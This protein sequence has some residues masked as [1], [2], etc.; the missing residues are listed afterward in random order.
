MERYQVILT[1]DGTRYIGY[2]IQARH[3]ADLT[4][5][6]V[7]ENALRRLGWQGTHILAAGR[8][9]TGVH[10]TGQVIAFDLEWKQTPQKLLSALNAHLPNDI[11]ALDVRVVEPDFHPRYQAISRCYRYRLFS[12]PIRQPLLERYAWRIWP[13]VDISAMKIVAGQLC[14]VQD[15]AAFGTPA[16]AGGS[17]IRR[18]FSANWKLVAYSDEISGWEFEVTADGFLYHMVRRLVFIQV[19]VGQGII[20]SESIQ[21]LFETPPRIPIQGLAP[22]NGLTLIRVTY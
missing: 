18:V 3:L 13:E 15:F 10:A 1:Y 9:D 7:V 21:T 16:K 22:A 19:Q 14:G 12:L 11:A 5:Q 4:I 17:T 2:Q 6:G 20:H 8:T